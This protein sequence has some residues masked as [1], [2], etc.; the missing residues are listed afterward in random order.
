MLGVFAAWPFSLCGTL[1]AVPLYDILAAVPLLVCGLAALC[2]I[3][4]AVPLVVSDSFLQLCR[5]GAVPLS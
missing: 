5:L 2:G 3:L 4:A 1:A